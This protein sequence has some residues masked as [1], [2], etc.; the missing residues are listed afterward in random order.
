MHNIAVLFYILHSFSVTAL[1]RPRGV[2]ISMASFYSGQSENFSCLD[3]SRVIP[4]HY[5]NDDYCDCLDGSDEPGTSACINGNFHCT[6]AGY[7]PTNIPSSR[8]NDGYCDC[9]DGQDEYDGIIMCTNKCK[10]L[11]KQAQEE[12]QK[13]HKM[14]MEGYAKKQEFIS[15][16]HVAIEEKKNKLVELENLK[17]AAEQKKIE[18]EAWK[19]EAEGPEKSAKEAHEKIHEEEKTRRQHEE[20]QNRAKEAFDELDINR[21]HLLSV[22]EM[23]THLEFDIDSDG[24]VS[25]DEA[26]EYMEDVVEADYNHFVEKMWPNIKEI[27]NKKN[28]PTESDPSTVITTAD[29][30]PTPETSE[31]DQL[32]SASTDSDSGGDG[33]DADSDDEESDGDYDD[34]EDNYDDA[35]KKKAKEPEK[36]NTLKMPEYDEETKKL[37]EVADRAREEFNEA[38]RKLRE[39]EKSISDVKKI[40]DLD[41]GPENEYYMLYGKCFEFSDREYIYTF[42]P[43]DRTSQRSKSGG[44]ETSL[45]HWGLWDGP[46][47]D[48]YSKQKYDRGQ[49]CWNGP[50][51]SVRIHFECG[52][53]NQ[54]KSA[55]EP[56]RCEYA[57]TFATPARCTKQ[58]AS[59]AGFATKDEL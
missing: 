19:N 16:G 14:Q 27:Y 4:F 21:D 15:E 7:I 18:M 3:S 25:E 11:G 5:V 38:D 49:N 9:C 44:M 26:K 20:E 48:L 29:V 22:L 32:E 43:F 24:T 41:L 35:E 57:F 54:L 58:E 59:S 17:I 34:E 12:R 10:E 53:E 46:Q 8:V 31:K 45:G 40:L 55:S 33:D 50:D 36:E 6:N 39:V 51:R 42:C 37:I 2:S 52:I 47:T 28:K 23:K 13:I 1:S 56:N 30:T